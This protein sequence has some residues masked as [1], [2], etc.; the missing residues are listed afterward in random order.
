M[1]LRHI[2]PTEWP[3]V[4]PRIMPLVLASVNTGQDEWDIGALDIAI[5]RGQVL[6]FAVVQDG[7]AVAFIAGQFIYYPLKTTFLVTFLAGRLQQ[8]QKEIEELDAFAR[9]GGATEAEAYARDSV[10][11]RLR[12]Y[13]FEKVANFL[14]RPLA[15]KH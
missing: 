5:Q 6:A 9:A 12:K 15:V 13:G 4:L 1:S 10:A 11:R 8:C 14:R 2:S 7:M 3:T